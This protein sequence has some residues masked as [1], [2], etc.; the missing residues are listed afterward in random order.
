MTPDNAPTLPPGASMESRVR[1]LERVMDGEQ[2]EDNPGLR[3]RVRDMESVLKRY[4]R[5]ELMIKGAFVM[6]GF[7][8]ASGAIS[9]VEFVI[10]LLR[11]GVP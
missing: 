1:R 2:N 3:G 11:G 7:A 6:S 10:K 9:L 5:M 8:G 4:E